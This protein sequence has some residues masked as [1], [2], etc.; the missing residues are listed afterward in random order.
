MFMVGFVWSG[1]MYSPA[2]LH[3]IETSL[4]ALDGLRKL[5]PSIHKVVWSR[6]Q[7]MACVGAVL[8]MLDGPHWV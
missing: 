3:G 6:R 5:R 2:A 4:L 7:P 1:S 8:S